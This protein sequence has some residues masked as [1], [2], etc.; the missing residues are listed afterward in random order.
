[1][2]TRTASDGSYSFDNL[3]SNLEPAI[4]YRVVEVLPNNLSQSTTNPEPITFSRGETV[5]HVD[6]GNTSKK[7]TSTTAISTVT[8][9]G[10]TSGSLAAAL[11]DIV[12]LLN[13]GL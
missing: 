7:A 6:F 2:Q 3:S 11:F 4:A 9:S 10:T 1:A 5:S 12:H 8:D 13:P